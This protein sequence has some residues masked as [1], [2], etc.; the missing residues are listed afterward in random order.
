MQIP[1][2]IERISGNGYRAKSGEPLALCV[3]GSTREDALAKFKEQLQTRL[4]RGAELVPMPLTPEQHPL[5]EFVGMFRDDPWIED[6]KKSV[7]EYRRK[8]DEDADRP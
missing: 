6:W 1:V 7:A 2:L 8:I 5:A 4:S 3:E